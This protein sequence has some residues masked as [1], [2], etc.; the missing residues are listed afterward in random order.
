M[1][2]NCDNATLQGNMFINNIGS[3]GAN[4]YG[5][6]LY[7]EVSDYLV[8]SGNTFHGNTA[9]QA[10]SWGGGLYMRRSNYALLNQ[11]IFED[12]TASTFQGWGG[13]IYLEVTEDLTM[14]GNLVRRNDGT[15]N[16]SKDSWGGGI[17]ID[18]GGPYTLTNNAIIDNTGNTAGSGIY[19]NEASPKFIHTTITGNIGGDGS[20]IY[21]TGTLNT[22][23]MTNTLIANQILGLHVSSNSSAILNTSLWY[24]ND[25][26]WGGSGDINHS[27]D[28]YSDP[29]LAADGYHL[30]FA[31]AVI[32][33]GLD[34][35][36]VT[37]IDGDTRPSRSGYDIGADEFMSRN[38]LPFLVHSQ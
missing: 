14:N 5:G 9:G 4:Y 28:H 7:I 24:D 33:L 15:S 3:G 12:N 2:N 37:D 6:G 30:G 16:L 19:V 29:G 8:L 13:G 26:N 36:M 23:A 18:R 21:I 34:A 27:Q 31:S 35:G 1:I 11:N 25:T 38:Y 22:V 10:W 20:G 32:D 17:Y